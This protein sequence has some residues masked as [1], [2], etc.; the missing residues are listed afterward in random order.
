MTATEPKAGARHISQVPVTV[1]ITGVDEF[2]E[3][4]YTYT[5][6]ATGIVHVNAVFADIVAVVP[7]HTMFVLDYASTRNGWIFR[8][9]IID[10]GPTPTEH[11]LADNAMSMVTLDKQEFAKHRF[12][13]VFHNRYTEARLEDDPQEGNVRQPKLV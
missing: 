3:V 9:E 11:K 8:D 5:D 4:F 7:Y 6:L 10:R 13:L 12:Y 1:S 2:S